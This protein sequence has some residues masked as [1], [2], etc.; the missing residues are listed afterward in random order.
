MKLDS[1]QLKT[2]QEI[3]ESKIDQVVNTLEEKHKKEFEDFKKQT[4][5]VTKLSEAFGRSTVRTLF[6]NK[7]KNINEV[8]SSALAIFLNQHASTRKDEFER[9]SLKE[10]TEA[11]SMM[12]LNTFYSSP[13]D[14]IS[15]TEAGDIN[16]IQD[17][18]I[19]IIQY[20]KLRFDEKEKTK[21]FRIKDKITSNEGIPFCSSKP[22][23]EE[24]KF[25]SELGFEISKAEPPKDKNTASTWFK[26]G[27]LSGKRL[28]K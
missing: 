17:F 15:N 23:S 25:L 21:A 28:S 13:T 11:L 12:E 27:C 14:Q 22:K 24:E 20:Y 3:I 7:D 19:D 10:C 5:A 2:I 4:K 6:R 8:I 26:P 18:I 16:E 1:I 9:A